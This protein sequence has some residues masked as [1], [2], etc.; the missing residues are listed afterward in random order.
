MDT[1]E[2]CERRA[3]RLAALLS[4]DSVRA[5]RIVAQALDAQ[6]DPTL[7]PDARLDR[8][9]ILRAREILGESRDPRNRRSPRRLPRLPAPG[10]LLD[11]L[12]ASHRQARG[13]VRSRGPVAVEQEDIRLF[14]GEAARAHEALSSLSEQAREAWILRELDGKDM[15]EIA[16]AMDCSKTA[17]ARHLEQAR[18]RMTLLLGED[19]EDALGALRHGADRLDPGAFIARRAVVKKRGRRLRLIVWL[20]MVVIAIVMCIS[21][22]GRLA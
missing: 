4:G 5:E 19:A 10:V 2:A 20:V 22:W 13:E 21:V 8:L 3:W 18:D 1:S 9:V 15:I 12:R 6:P 11:R 17:A 14:H 7:L 16:R